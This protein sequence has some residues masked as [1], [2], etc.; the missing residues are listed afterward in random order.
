VTN[1]SYL[2][3]L[4]C[5]SSKHYRLVSTF[6]SHQKVSYFGMRHVV[7]TNRFNVTQ[8]ANSHI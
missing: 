1:T 2:L 8:C 5:D 4:C 7:W 6:C 3:S